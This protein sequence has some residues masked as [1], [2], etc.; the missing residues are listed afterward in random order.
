MR[1]AIVSDIHGNQRAFDAVLGDLREV[2]PDLVIHGGDLSSG[3][4]HPAE[5]VDQIQSLGWP[6]VIGNTD[7]MLYAPDRLTDSPQRYRNSRPF[8]S[9]SKTRFHGLSTNSAPIARAGSKNFQ[10]VTCAKT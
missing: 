7:E 6:G 2:A 10:H 1:I 5:I 8:F 3:G 9:E 4:V